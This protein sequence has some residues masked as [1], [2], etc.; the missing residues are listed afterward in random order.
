MLNGNFSAEDKRKAAA[1]F[2]D[3]K[4][5]FFNAKMKEP[6]EYD[7]DKNNIFETLIKEAKEK[8]RPF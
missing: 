1:L 8:T 2:I 4:G 5:K 3:E 7:R 6:K